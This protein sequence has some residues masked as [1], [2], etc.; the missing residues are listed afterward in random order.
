MG[1]G[2]ECPYIPGRR[3]LDWDLPDPKGMPIEAVRAA[4]G[5]DRRADEAL[6][7]ELDRAGPGLSREAGAGC[8]RSPRRRSCEPCQPD[9]RGPAL[10]AIFIALGG[11]AMATQVG[12]PAGRDDGE[13]EGEAKPGAR[14]RPAMVAGAIGASPGAR[15]ARSAG[16]QQVPRVRRVPRDQRAQPVRPVTTGPDRASRALPGRRAQST[17]PRAATSPATYPNRESP[18]GPSGPR[19]P[20][21]SRPSGS[22]TRPTRPSPGDPCRRL[23]V[24]TPSSSTPPAMHSTSAATERPDGAGRRN[25]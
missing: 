3:Y 14:G 25:L 16:H 8:N 22:A 5:G 2:D 6:V 12:E 15:V 17:G 23:S 1:C 11:T 20:G 24:S 18:P 7:D 19:R 9:D 4:A 13:E 10:V 21:R